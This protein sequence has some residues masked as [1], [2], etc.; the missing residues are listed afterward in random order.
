M[1]EEPEQV[2]GLAVV[3]T[4]AEPPQA[5][6]GTEPNHRHRWSGRPWRAILFAPIGDGQTR[7]RG[8]DGVRVGLSLLVVLLCWLATQVNPSSEKALVN[9][10]TPVPNGLSWLVTSVG[11][12]GSLGLIAVAIALA[13][14]SKRTAVIRDIVLSGAGAWMACVLLGVYFGPDGG[15]PPGGA[16]HGYDLGV[17]GGPGGGHGGGGHR[18]PAVPEPVAAA[19]H[20]GHRGP[21]GGGDGGVRNR[22]FPSPCWPAW[23]SAS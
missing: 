15:R 9:A 2:Q 20:P 5:P 10:V 19:H 21:P 1:G 6:A 12:I 22:D 23:R 3:R 4:S 18:R 14:I 17:P 8:S 11:W 16:P 13:L 7:R